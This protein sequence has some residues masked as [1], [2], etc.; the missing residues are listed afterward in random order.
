[1]A[2]ISSEIQFR[3]SGG[4]SNSAPGSSIGGTKSSTSITTATLNN[5]W[6]NVSGDEAAAGDTEY[7][8]VYLHNANA[9]LTWEQV[10][11]WISA[12]TPAA[13]TTC[14]IGLG[15][16][17]VNATETAVANEG[18]AP[19]GVTFSAPTSKAGG[20]LIGDIP[21]GQAKAIWI[22][23]VVTA[24]AAAYNADSVVIQAEGDSA[25]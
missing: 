13:G 24:G 8:C 5:L 1:M 16:A 4:A 12:N 20:L 25:S 6:D 17:A 3:L 22:K 19:A 14:E 23:R 7:R 18:V 2:I 21:A 10:T 9:T 15:A 11:V